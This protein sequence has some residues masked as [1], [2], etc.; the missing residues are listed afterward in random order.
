MGGRDIISQAIE[1][2]RFTKKGLSLAAGLNHAYV[3]Q[4]L[5]GVGAPELPE[6]VREKL[7]PIL[8]VHPDALREG[9][10]RQQALIETLASDHGGKLSNTE[11]ERA[12]IELW[13]ELDPLRRVLM[14]LV[15]EAVISVLGKKSA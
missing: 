10:G 2:K 12:I 3:Y 14:I 4:F 13:R 7:A 5:K 9:G 1:S 6:K 15:T 8:G 11:S